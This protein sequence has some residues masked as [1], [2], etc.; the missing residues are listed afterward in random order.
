MALTQLKSA[1]DM[2]TAATA[3]LTYLKYLTDTWMTLALWH[4]WSQKGRIEASFILK[5]SIEGVIPTTNHLEAFNG[6]L[7]RK[8]I[9]RWQHAG[10]RLRFDLFIYLLITQILPGIFYNR[11]AQETYLTWL[12][13]RF[14]VEAG[15]VD[16][17]AARKALQ[18]SAQAPPANK[19]VPVAVPVAWW[20]AESQE[21]HCDEAAYIVDHDRLA[22][23][24][25]VST[26]TIVATCASSM[27]DIQL[28]GHKRYDLCLSTQGWAH[29]ACQYFQSG[30]GACKHLWALRIRV[31]KLITL[32]QLPPA[33]YPFYFAISEE[34][35]R[36]IHQKYFGN[37]APA[38]QE[39]LSSQANPS[40]SDLPSPAE[41]AVFNLSA[42]D[43]INS[44]SKHANNW[45]LD[46]VEDSD[47][48]EPLVSDSDTESVDSGGIRASSTVRMIYIYP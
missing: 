35:A 42:I 39:P 27:S 2:A 29:C 20:S 10:K 15:G 46:T 41:P 43:S 12:S 34:E 31:P 37:A 1:L 24:W 26:S 7:K 48:G 23:I 4:G 3:G 40:L 14:R 38:P 45:L 47:G 5:I 33:F 21:R 9:H 17:I 36:K 6:V 30:Y 8:H 22:D 16:L 18:A 28:V 32:N 11:N 13:N 19:V 44:V 25:W